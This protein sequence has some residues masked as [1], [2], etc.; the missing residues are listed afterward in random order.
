MRFALHK[1]H[2]KKSSKKRST[3]R[4]S[5]K[6]KCLLTAYFHHLKR[7]DDEEDEDEMQE[8]E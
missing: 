8:N 4:I 5:R 2:I 3:L 1:F 6:L 7:H